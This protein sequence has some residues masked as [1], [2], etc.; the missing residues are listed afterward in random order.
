VVGR[1]RAGQSEALPG[2]GGARPGP[3]GAREAVRGALGGGDGNGTCESNV[4]EREAG[5]KKGKTEYY[6]HLCLSG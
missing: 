2:P 4:R 3:S 5:E 1:G 6:T